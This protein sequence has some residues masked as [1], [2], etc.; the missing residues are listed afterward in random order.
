MRFPRGVHDK[1]WTEGHGAL[2]PHLIHRRILNFPM[3]ASS[4][5]PL[6]GRTLGLVLA[7]PVALGVALATLAWVRGDAW[8]VRA[9]EAVNAQ[10]EGDLLVDDITLSWWNGFPD[11]SV[12]LAQVAVTNAQQDTLIEA[13]RIGLE[14]N[15]WSLLSDAPDI[16]AVTL[17]EGRLRLEQDLQGTWNVEAM[18]REQGQG[19]DNA[20]APSL[21]QVK[22][23]N[24]A[25]SVALRQERSASMVVK[26]GALALVARHAVDCLGLGPV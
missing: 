5:L 10:L 13:K 9:V 24:M 26:E 18:L 4:P 19:S 1:V 22:L 6:R 20:P 12:D 17:E 21:A 2:Q 8:K 7:I 11:M 16:H 23:K 14:L 3:A 15:V 25:L